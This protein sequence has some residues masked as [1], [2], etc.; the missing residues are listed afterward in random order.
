MLRSG[1]TSVHRTSKLTLPVEQV[2]SIITLMYQHNILRRNN[3]VTQPDKKSAEAISC[4]SRWLTSDTAKTSLMIYGTIGSGKTT[5][6]KALCSGIAKIRERAEAH[7]NDN[8]WKM[9]EEE[10]NNLRSDI[11]SLPSTHYIPALQI[12]EVAK[13]AN[14]FSNLMKVAGIMVIDDLG[15]EETSIK[16]FGT[17]RN[18]IIELINYRYDHDLTIVITTNLDDAGIVTRYGER[19]MDRL[20]EQCN[21]ISCVGESYRR[22]EA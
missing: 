5:L 8:G 3:N 6:A 1:L 21:V 14:Q 20:R 11:Y 7:L 2:D 16:D 12:N 9:S 15:T 4:V 18:P 10:R 22:Q 13:N 17:V 19:I